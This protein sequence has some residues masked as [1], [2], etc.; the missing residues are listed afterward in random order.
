MKFTIL[1]CGGSMGVPQLCCDCRVCK[2]DNPKNIRTRCSLLIEN[3]DKKIL[4]DT[5][6]DFRE[7]ALKNNIR[8]L[9]AL[10]YT[11]VHYDHIAGIDE[12]K[13]IAFN[14][15]DR[16]LETYMTSE[17][18][19]S[20]EI[21]NFYAFKSHSV[22]RPFL[23]ANTIDYYEK[24]NIANTE[25]Q[26]FKQGHGENFSSLGIRVGNLAYSTDVNSLPKESVDVLKGVDVWILDCLRYNWAPTHFTF[27]KTLEMIDLVK[28]KKTYLI[29]MAHEID[30]E[31]IKKLLPDNV[32]PAY[33]GLVIDL[34]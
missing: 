5:T 19:E 20:L 15:K 16:V 12:V 18:R 8:S 7:Q 23:K 13:P 27:E 34:K 28:P 9:D 26:F 25:I 31:E 3:N 24:R 11:H 22:Y 32:L 30:Y 4:V 10:I 14:N 1:G 6:P 33:D 29:H 21:T 17:T 2:S